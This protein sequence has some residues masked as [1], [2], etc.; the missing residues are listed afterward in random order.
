M[1]NGVKRPLFPVPHSSKSK[2]MEKYRTYL[3]NKNLSKSTVTQYAQMAEQLLSYLQKEGEAITYQDLL[4]YVNYLKRQGLPKSSINYRLSGLR[5][6]FA[7]L[8]GSGVRD[9]HPALH[10][11][12]KGSGATTRNHY[13]QWLAFEELEEVFEKYQEVHE[14]ETELQVLLSLLVFQGVRVSELRGL[15]VGH[16]NLKTGKITVPATNKSN[17]RILSLDLRQM[18]L[19]VQFLNDKQGKLFAYSYSK[20]LPNRVARLMKQLKTLHPG[21]INSV[22]IRSSVIAHWLKSE[23]LRVVQYQAG[24]RY[25]SSTERYQVAHLEELQAEISQIHPLS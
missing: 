16:I 8:L 22:Q 13:G 1:K 21:I 6:Y 24:H 5:H 14:S 19:L 11:R 9:D 7:W 15:E 4:S 18:L 20:G 3:E 10:L 12:L 25:V 17:S 23:D 2:N